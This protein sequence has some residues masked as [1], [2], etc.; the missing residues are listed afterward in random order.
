MQRP[1]ARDLRALVT[2]VA[3]KRTVVGDGQGGTSKERQDVVP[4]HLTLSP[5]PLSFLLSSRRKQV[6]SLSGA[7]AFQAFTCS[8]ESEGSL[9]RS[10]SSR[11]VVE[12][13]TPARHLSPFS[14][15]RRRPLGQVRGFCYR[16][17]H[18]T[19]ARE[20][21]THLLPCLLPQSSQDAFDKEPIELCSQRERRRSSD[22]PSQRPVHSR[23]EA[24]A[25]P[26]PRQS[27]ASSTPRR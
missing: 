16:L 25:S 1:R 19:S 26:Q 18:R 10:S 14:F 9:W 8:S 3:A 22:W 6:R 15:R 7:Q 2:V 5:F 27:N 24:A 20:R 12:P 4:T 17:V 23:V 21:R 13:R 11:C